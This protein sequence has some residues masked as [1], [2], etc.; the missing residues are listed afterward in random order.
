VIRP[1]AGRV[2]QFAEVAADHGHPLVGGQISGRRRLVD[3]RQPGQ[4][5]GPAA[6]HLDRARGQQFPGKAGTEEAGPAGD[7]HVRHGASGPSPVLAGQT[8]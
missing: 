7:H 1:G 2:E 3:E 8:Q 5:P 4:R 6:C